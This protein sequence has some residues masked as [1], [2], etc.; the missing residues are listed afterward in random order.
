MADLVK[1]KF[2]IKLETEYEPIEEG[3]G[4]HAWTEG[5]W[6]R[7]FLLSEAEFECYG[8]YCANYLDAITVVNEQ[9]PNL[10]VSRRYPGGPELL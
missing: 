2:L 6:G 3:N 5:S 10:L 1:R 9:M 4:P 7:P 8:P